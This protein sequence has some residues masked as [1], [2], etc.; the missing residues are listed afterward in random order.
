MSAITATDRVADFAPPPGV[1]LVHVIGVVLL[2]LDIVLV[3]ATGFAADVIYHGL[4]WGERGSDYA[5]WSAF[6]VAT[7]FAVLQLSHGAYRPKRLLDATTSSAAP[8]MTG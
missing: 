4:I 8:G 7:I 6:G 3:A 2:A 1:N 5:A